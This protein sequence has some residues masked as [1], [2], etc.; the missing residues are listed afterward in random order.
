M[1]ATSIT[2]DVDG[3]DDRLL[4]LQANAPEGLKI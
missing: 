2:P 4:F 1:G 3:R